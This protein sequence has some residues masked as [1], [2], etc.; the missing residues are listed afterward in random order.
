MPRKFS[1]LELKT[2]IK[3]HIDDAHIKQKALDLLTT[4]LLP[5]AQGAG[6]GTCKKWCVDGN[7]TICCDPPGVNRVSTNRLLLLK[8]ID[9]IAKDSA[10]N[11]I[12]VKETKLN[13]MTEYK[14]VAI[15]RKAKL[16]EVLIP[17]NQAG[18]GNHL[19]LTFN[20]PFT[21]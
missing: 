14:V 4:L 6:P 1:S 16:A 12:P 17:Q 11:N 15:P 3:L 9:V 21:A 20:L 7:N 13:N 18:G 8:S 19:K 2:V 10:G 5:G